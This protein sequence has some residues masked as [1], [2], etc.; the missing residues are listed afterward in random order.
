MA[1]YLATVACLAGSRVGL[2]LVLH[3]IGEFAGRLIQ[4]RKF[5][6]GLGRAFTTIAGSLGSAH[7]G[8]HHGRGGSSIR[9][10]ALSL[11]QSTK[12]RVGCRAR[13]GDDYLVSS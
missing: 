11:S 8:R 5:H 9:P 6:L 4:A 13:S 1:R 7:R 2:Q 12:R 10:G 3:D